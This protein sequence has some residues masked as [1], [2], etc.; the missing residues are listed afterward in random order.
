MTEAQGTWLAVS[1]VA[2]VIMA[3]VQV[4]VAVAAILAARQVMRMN[5]ELRR[6]LGTLIARMNRMADDAERVVALAASQVERLDRFVGATVERVDQVAGFV[7]GALGGPLRQGA[8]A[9]SVV[10]AI[11][12]ALRGRRSSAGRRR[13]RDEDDALFVG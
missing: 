9:F 6:D 5:D 7:Q 1:A 8:L 3:L 2:L 4:G 12:G 13:R 11:V 10:R